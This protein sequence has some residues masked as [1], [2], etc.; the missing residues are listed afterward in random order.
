MAQKTLPKPSPQRARIPQPR[1]ML[2]P[3]AVQVGLGL[4]SSPVSTRLVL[5]RPAAESMSLALPSIRKAYTIQ[6]LAQSERGGSEP[7]SSGRQGARPAGASSP[8]SK[9]LPV[10]SDLRR[11]LLA[12]LAVP[13]ARLLPAETSVLE[14]PG[15]LRDF[16]IEGVGL[17][18]QQ[19]EVLLADDMGLG[20]TVQAIAAFRVLLRR[21]QAEAVLVVVPASLVMQWRR[22]IALWAPE[23]RV[24]I[25]RGSP[26]TRASQW[27]APAHVFLT[28]YETLRADNSP[29]PNSGPRR[30]C[31]D[32]VV[33]DEAQRIKNRDR[34]IS[35]A[36][37]GVPRHR[38]WAL[39]GTPLEN[40]VDDLTSI[41]E[42]LQPNHEGQPVAP[43]PFGPAAR[44]MHARLQLRRRKK[45]VL[46]ELPPKTVTDL[47]LDLT[48]SQ[49]AAYDRAEADGVVEL[50]A[51]GETVRVTHVLSLI[52]R[53]RQICNFCPTDGSSAKLADVTR[54]LADL[55]G[56]G[57]KMLL[58][59]Q[60]TDDDFGVR[61]IAEQLAEWGALSY[62][63]ALSQEERDAVVRRFK[64][65]PDNQVLVI[66]LRA[67]AQGLNLQEASY[68]VHFDRWWN[69]AIE[70][71]AEDRSHRMGQRYP[72]TVYTYT[73][74]GTIE[75]RIAELLEEKRKLF[76]LVIDDVTLD[77]ERV[78]TKSELFGLFDL[79]VPVAEETN[80]EVGASS[81]R[82]MTGREFEEW[83]DG[84]F[85]QLGFAVEL[86][87][88]SRDGGVD[89]IARQTDVVGVETVLYI[90]CKNYAAP[91][92]VEPVRALVG[93][94]PP[95]EPGAR[96]A[97]VCPGGFTADAMKY[98]SL[99]GVQMVDSRGLAVL[100]QRASVRSKTP[101]GQPSLGSGNCI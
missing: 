19:P 94:L 58:F 68:V 8:R 62:T 99:R 88:A 16:Q 95:D 12:A 11:R 60:F 56:Q 85:R 61:A 37:K 41:L 49:R 32:V 100:V 53:L 38:S 4:V 3:R 78:L 21:G 44:E 34:D 96:A 25:V 101:S 86:T 54:R 13:L 6:L 76:K 64:T 42:F 27:A 7:A 72:V 46:A 40:R 57:H 24:S 84:L 77:L 81:F 50:R 22:E 29:H 63:G 48:P 70:S 10:A 89:L 67:G 69:P 14:W 91:I 26:T 90:Q 31:W 18:L 2:E 92:G 71:Q 93:C 51:R 15:I 87:P 98:G 79:P 52:T 65:N 28:S 74:A 1:L 9:D 75:E 33:L 17:L 83:A 73:M 59:S 35:A 82:E 39:T 45:D 43:I 5:S 20:K 23:L 47:T 80:I 66:S 30:R 55:A 97:M 36:C